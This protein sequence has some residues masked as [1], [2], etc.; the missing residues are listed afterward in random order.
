MIIRSTVYNQV[1]NC[2]IARDDGMKKNKQ[3]QL[4]AIVTKVMQQRME[5]YTTFVFK[6]NSITDQLKHN[7]YPDH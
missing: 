5:M 1:W 7:C 6:F 2:G 3:I 4:N